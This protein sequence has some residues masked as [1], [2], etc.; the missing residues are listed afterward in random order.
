[1]AK[2]S[3]ELWEMIKSEFEAGASYAAIIEKY[4]VSKSTLSNRAT[5]EKWQKNKIKELVEE[6]FEAVS[7]VMKVQEKN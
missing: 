3:E 7:Q 2:L 6:K 4:G 5:R 1:M